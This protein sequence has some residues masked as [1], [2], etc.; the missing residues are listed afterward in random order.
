MKT[1]PDRDELLNALHG[2]VTVKELEEC[3]LGVLTPVRASDRI[4]FTPLL[5]P[6]T[7]SRV[8]GILRKFRPTRNTG[9]LLF[10]ERVVAVFTPHVPDNVLG[11]VELWVHDTLL[12]NLQEVTNRVRVR[13]NDGPKLIAFY[14]PYSI[15]LSDTSLGLPRS[16]SVVSE[17]HEMQFV[18]GGSPFSLYL[19][20]SP[21][22]EGV[23][24]NYLP[25]PP[26]ILPVCRTM[27]RDALQ[28]TAMQQ[29]YLAGAM[30]NRYATP[31]SG[32]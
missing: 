28:E 8:A 17:L 14:P 30:S 7:H 21:R 3:N 5:P 1:A 23:S 19:L 15:P 25:R 32:T 13:L 6:R 27:V 22:I 2:E 24:H 20:W 18:P 11:E 26:Q 10:I 9:G 16:F 4:T 29:S 12:P 31:T